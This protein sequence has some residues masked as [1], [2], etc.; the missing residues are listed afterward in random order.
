MLA[1]AFIRFGVFF[2]FLNVSVY[3]FFMPN[4]ES[5]QLLLLN[6]FFCLFVCLAHAV[7][8][9]LKLIGT[10]WVPKDM[11]A[12]LLSRFPQDPEALFIF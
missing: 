4:L 12:R 3:G 9:F 1:F 2:N 6:F 11:N 5:F 7:F 8:L 10:P